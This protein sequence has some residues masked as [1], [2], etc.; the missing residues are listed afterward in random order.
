METPKP[1]DANQPAG[2]VSPA[3]SGGQPATPAAAQ[4]AAQPTPGAELH[5]PGASPSPGA[6]P[7][8]G[9]VPITALHEE[10]TKRQ[11][12]ER[13][14]EQLREAVTQRAYEQQNHYQPQQQAPQ[15]NQGFTQEQMNQ[16]WEDNPR[17]AVQVEIMQHA[18]W[19]D[20]IEASVSQQA[21][22]LQSKYSDFNDYRQTAETYVR[23]LPLEQRANPRVMETAYF[24]VRGQNVDK[25][26][27]KQK[28]TL[29]QQFQ[30]GGP[31]GV[32]MPAAGTYSAP[33]AQ[34]GVQLTPEQLTAA[35]AMGL[36]PEAYAGSIVSR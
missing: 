9:S 26:L 35:A 8:T 20:A 15:P 29:Y 14:V 31:A 4:P 19:R 24:I 10:R 23:S 7:D 30:Q 11:S 32:S 22:Q 18:A 27:E 36:T 6:K 17:Q 16:M 12:L 2:N 13:E 1:T 21:A 33:P 3:P 25:V 5:Q 28:E 34:P